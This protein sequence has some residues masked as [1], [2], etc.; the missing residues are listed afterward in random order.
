LSIRTLIHKSILLRFRIEITFDST[1]LSFERRFLLFLIR[2]INSMYFKHTK[3]IQS[4]H[5]CKHSIKKQ[6]QLVLE[7][8]AKFLDRILR[9]SYGYGKMATMWTILQNRNL[10]PLAKKESLT[11]ITKIPLFKQC[12]ILS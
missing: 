10:L 1:L 6:D 7:F 5:S 3:Q 2:N 4:M 8:T 9:F 12:Q 11:K